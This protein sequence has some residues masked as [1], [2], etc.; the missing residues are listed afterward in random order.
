[1]NK[2]E[3]L[4]KLLDVKAGQ[5]WDSPDD[6]LK[7]LEYA[8]D[9][10]QSLVKEYFYEK[11]I[12]ELATRICEFMQNKLDNNPGLR[13]NVND[14]GRLNKDHKKQTIKDLYLILSEFSGPELSNIPVL[15][16]EKDTRVTAMADSTKLLVN[17]FNVGMNSKLNDTKKLL[18]VIV[19]EY[20]HLLQSVG[21]SAVSFEVLNLAKE[22]YVGFTMLDN[23]NDENIKALT[24]KCWENNIREKE[25]IFIGEYVSKNLKLD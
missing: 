16:W 18:H 10:H 13:N 23:L 11:D 24:G 5:P 1:M 7:T 15:F 4:Q 19:H 21:K 14:F 25:A 9:F 12:I 6:L 22:Y 20:T 2:D 8:A 17:Y 3:R